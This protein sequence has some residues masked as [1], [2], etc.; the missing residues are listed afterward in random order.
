MSLLKKI[1]SDL[2]ESMKSANGIK[3]KTL[4]MLKS[5]IMYEKGKTGE[6]LSD[7][8]ILQVITRGAKRRK[9]SIKEY[10]KGNREDLVKIEEAELEVIAEYLPEQMSEEEIKKI[11]DETIKGI[12]TVTKKDMG[13]IMGMIMKDLKGTVDG[14]VVRN[15]LTNKLEDWLIKKI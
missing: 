7:E 8:E 6:D 3:A 11:I 2:K 4:K 14:N 1:E 15:I 9:E 13:R 12:G 10:K 5:D